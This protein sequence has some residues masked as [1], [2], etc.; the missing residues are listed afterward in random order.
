[1][2]AKQLS[3]TAKLMIV[4]MALVAGTCL[5]VGGMGLFQVRQLGTDISRQTGDGLREEAARAL[6]AG[7]DTDRLRITNTIESAEHEC[8]NLA[9]SAGVQNYLTAQDG[10][11]T[12][13]TE[14]STREAVRYV[15]GAKALCAALSANLKTK[16]RSDLELATEVLV[17]AGNAGL[18]DTQKRTWNTINQATKQASEQSLPTMLIGQTPVVPNDNPEVPS[19]VVDQVR[20]TVG[21]YCTLFQRLNDAGD[22]LR[23]VT[24]V[25][26]NGKR[27]IGTYIPA[28]MPDG[29]ANTVIKTVLAGKDYIGRA[30]VVD[31]WYVTAYRPLK[32][33]AGQ[34]IGMIFVGTPEQ[35]SAELIKHIKQTKIGRTG[36]PYVCDSKGT[37][38]VHPRPE[39]VG[40]NLITDL[41]LTA[42]QAMLSTR[43]ESEVKCLD[44]D[45]EGRRKFALYSYFPEWD[46]IICASGYRDDLSDS[47]ARF[48]GML[49]KSQMANSYRC[50]LQALDGQQVPYLSQIRFLNAK[51]MEVFKLEGGNNSDDLKDKSTTDWFKATAALP[52][53][54]VCNSGLVISANTGLPEI[55]IASPVYT[56]KSFRGAFVLSIDGRVVK[57]AVS[58]SHYGKTGYSY[59][60]D[61]TGLLVAHPKY[62]ARDGFRLTDARNGDLARIAKE[63]FLSGNSGL[64][65]YHDGD[66]PMTAAYQPFKMGNRPYAVIAAI[67]DAELYQ[68]CQQIQGSVSDRVRAVI[69]ILLGTAAGLVVVGSVAGAWLSRSVVRP[70]RRIIAHMTEGARQVASSSTQVSS[71]S[72]ALAQGA[73]TQAAA[74][75]QTSASLEEMTS[76]T[77]NNSQAAQQARALASEANASAASG[78]RATERMTSAISEIERRANETARIVKVIDEI[79]F[80]TNLL[81]LN[82]AVEAAR[83]GEAGRGFAVVA[84]EVRSLA[85]RSA[86]AARSTASLIEQSVQA[87]KEGVAI[88]ADVAEALTGITAAA[89]KVNALVEEIAAGS[90]Q[91]ATGIEQVTQAV[92]HIDQTTQSNAASAEQ[93]ASAAQELSAQASNFSTAVL[94]LERVVNGGTKTV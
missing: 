91:Q 87:A 22:M 16:L 83:A 88:T 13:L 74:I 25:P 30:K 71:S 52:S 73:S 43:S 80:Q 36:Y 66:V 46:W 75:E 10:S 31:A 33:S 42:L 56:D 20:Q 76:M 81:A 69:L 58:K 29:V 72:N 82:A 49:L 35:E 32:D 79:A 78:Q 85:G 39:L 21:S 51:G 18:S 9:S 54:S 14:L 7:A 12:I 65:S 93:S 94:E 64:V 34:V 2:A 15:E 8:V 63:Q 67:P 68:V 5:V 50:S 45:F 3:L 38:L 28:T 26:A 17:H 23:I 84:E 37:L 47:S 60:I 40:K 27:A 44:Y 62:S 92:S 57:S 61:D 1:M 59:V 6:L 86:E 89:G 53:G 41:K 24:N 70:V 11:N 90:A 55:R 77:K 48:A 19:P 4:S